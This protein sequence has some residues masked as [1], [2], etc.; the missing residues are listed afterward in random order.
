MADEAHKPD[1]TDAEHAGADAGAEQ[2]VQAPDAEEAM[3]SVEQAAEQVKSAVEEEPVVLP[4]F[5]E[6]Q[7]GAPEGNGLRMG[8]LDDVSLNVKIE[9]GRTHMYVED[10]LR[11]NAD[12]VIELDK[13]A[14]DHVD[15]FVNDRL[16]ARGEVLVLND[17]FCVR[18]SEILQPRVPRQE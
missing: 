5:G 4:E 15:I 12:S 1:P 9:L 2:D 7:D 6:E 14:G 13:A 17:N 3:E 10:V 11:L 16:V 8:L 18:V